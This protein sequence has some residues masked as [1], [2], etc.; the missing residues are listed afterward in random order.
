MNLSLILRLPFLFFYF[1]PEHLQEFRLQEHFFDCYKNFKDH[2]NDFTHSVLEAYSIRDNYVIVD[3]FVA[4]ELDKVIQ[5]I[6]YN[7]ELFADEFF[8]EENVSIFIHIE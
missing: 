8:K 2:L 6:I 5:L 1:P 3:A 4:I 7:F